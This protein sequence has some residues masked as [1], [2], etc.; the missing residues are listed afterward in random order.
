MPVRSVSLAKKL[1]ALPHSAFLAL[2]RDTYAGLLACIEVV[3]LQARVLLALWSESRHEEQRRKARRR[4]G[5]APAGQNGVA[6][7]SDGESALLASHAPGATLAVPGSA[8]E[9]AVSAAPLPPDSSRSSA[10]DDASSLGTDITDV[11]HAV[12]EL[13]NVRFSKVVGVRT[14]VHAHLALADFVEIFDLSWSFVVACE[15]VCQRMIVG[16]RGAMVSQAKTFVQTFHQRQITENARVVE[17]E[18]WAAA[19]VPPETQANI[20]LILDGA[21]SDPTALLLGER[22]TARLAA[23]SSTAHPRLDADV[24][25][26]A[27]VEPAKQIDIEGRQFFA[28]SAGLVTVAV[29]VEYLKVLANVPMLTT[30]AM[31]KIIEFMKVRSSLSLKPM[32]EPG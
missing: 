8:A 28:V 13:A 3:D 26:P 1:R 20:Q 6:R 25:A 9:L 24:K 27:E 30:D 10:T 7:A 29:L 5:S 21:T 31:S 18:Q 15:R 4:S 12:A 16:L 32:L 11:V 19:E 17:E 2:A 22:R 23:E 14:E